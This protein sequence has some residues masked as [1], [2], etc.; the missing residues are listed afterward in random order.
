MELFKLYQMVSSKATQHSGTCVGVSVCPKNGAIWLAISSQETTLA[1][2]F[3]PPCDIFA[4]TVWV[5]IE[6]FEFDKIIR[7]G[8]RI[9]NRIEDSGQLWT[10]LCLFVNLG[11]FCPPLRTPSLKSFVTQKIFVGLLNKLL[12]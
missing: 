12:Y 5:K 6:A 2:L 10:V 4:A 11:K 7:I 9:Y 3:W 1:W 8:N